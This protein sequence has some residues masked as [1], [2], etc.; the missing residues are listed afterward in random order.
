MS[1]APSP[2][3]LGFS[4]S[5]AEEDAARAGAKR[6][7]RNHEV[8][9]LRQAV[10]PEQLREMSQTR[11]RES[12]SRRSRLVARVLHQDDFGAELLET[13]AMRF[14]VTLQS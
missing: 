1:S 6:R 5:V 7:L 12:P 2:A 4:T 14:E 9:Q 10:F 11:R 13:A 8:L 3:C